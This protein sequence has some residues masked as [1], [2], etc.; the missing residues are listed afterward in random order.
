MDHDRVLL[1]LVVGVGEKE[2]EELVP[3]ELLQRPEEGCHPFRAAPGAR[4]GRGVAPPRRGPQLNAPEGL[5]REPQ[6]RVAQHLLAVEVAVGPVQEEQVLPLHVEDQRLGVVRAGTELARS[7]EAVQQ[8]DGVAGL[9]GHARD[10][11]DVDVGAPGAVQE[12]QIGVDD[13][14]V[15]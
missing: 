13:L 15:A 5:G 12:F 11:A 4:R 9:C 8:E 2:R 14:A 3:A 7:E 1:A 10:A 6:R